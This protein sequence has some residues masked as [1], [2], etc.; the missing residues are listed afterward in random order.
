[1]KKEQQSVRDLKSQIREILNKIKSEMPLE[2]VEKCL[3]NIYELQNPENYSKEPVD[4]SVVRS[5]YVGKVGHCCCGCSGT[6]YDASGYKDREVCKGAIGD[7]KKVASVVKKINKALASG[8]CAVS[9]REGFTAMHFG[10]RK[11]IAY[12]DSVTYKGNFPKY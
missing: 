4:I 9:N 5:V 1:M 7:D 6:H 2:K 3:L 8:K 10:N 12:H 11:Y